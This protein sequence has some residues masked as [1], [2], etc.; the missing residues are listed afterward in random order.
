M[1]STHEKVQCN[2]LTYQKKSK[3]CENEEEKGK[4]PAEIAHGGNEECLI[5]GSAL[6]EATIY[7]RCVL[8]GEECEIVCNKDRMCGGGA[9]YGGLC[10]I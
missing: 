9:D 4:D 10:G 6:T 2:E 7:A 3:M 5:R 8:F 1:S